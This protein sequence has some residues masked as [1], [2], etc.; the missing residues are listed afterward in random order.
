MGINQCWIIAMNSLIKTVCYRCSQ[1]NHLTTYYFRYILMLQR[2][3]IKYN[4]SL[5]QSDGE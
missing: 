5:I 1:K 3:K 2:Y 4:I